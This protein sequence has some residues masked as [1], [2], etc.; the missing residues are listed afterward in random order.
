MMTNMTKYS[1]LTKYKICVAVYKEKDMKSCLGRQHCHRHHVKPRS[2]YPE[3]ADDPSN[4]VVV[5]DI[6]HWALHKWLL[7]HYRETG[8]Q[9]AIE[10]MEKVDLETYINDSLKETKF[11]FSASSKILE[12]L[13]QVLALYVEKTRL[14]RKNLAVIYGGTEDGQTLKIKTGLEFEVPKALESVLVEDKSKLWDMPFPLRF[15]LRRDHLDLAMKNLELVTSFASF[16]RIKALGL[17]EVK[18]FDDTDEEFIK[19]YLG[20]FHDMALKSF[21]LKPVDELDIPDNYLDVIVEI[22]KL[23]DKAVKDA[24]AI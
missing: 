8:N 16:Q 6:V 21:G 17:E 14:P 5:P 7:E 4:I 12:R 15:C 18:L 10:K 24:D 11:D 1:N 13:E 2:L 9:A 3:L 20:E 23:I 19:H 22:E